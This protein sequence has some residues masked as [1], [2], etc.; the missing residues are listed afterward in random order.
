[1]NIGGLQKFSLIDYP[2]KIS[3]IVFTQGCN[4]RCPY[5][6]NPELVESKLFGSQINEEYIFSFLKSRMGKLDGVSITGGEPTLQSDLVDFI[7]EVKNMGYLVKLDTNGSMPEVLRKLLS[8]NLLDYIAMDVKT[9]LQKYSDIVKVDIDKSKIMESINIILDSNVEYEFRTTV[10]KNFLSKEDII[11][12]SRTIKGAKRYVLQKFVGIKTLDKSVI[13]NAEN[14]TNE[15][16][17]EIKESIKE[18]VEECS[19]R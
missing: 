8:E 10:L 4:F 3:T 7:Q 14:Y 15:E 16:L 18:Y 11:E 2:Q 13:D 9:T 19:I 17:N 6:H 12:I 5:C 1:M